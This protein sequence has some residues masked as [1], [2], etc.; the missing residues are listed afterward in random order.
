MANNILINQDESQRE[1]EIGIH[2][3]KEKTA[4][5]LSGFSKIGS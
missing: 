2:N 5:S 1:D 4:N 3:K